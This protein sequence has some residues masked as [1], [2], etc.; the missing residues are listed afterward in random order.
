MKNLPICGDSVKLLDNLNE[1]TVT[2]LGIIKGSI[3]KIVTKTEILALGSFPSGNICKW[4]RHIFG[5]M[6]N[7]QII[8]MDQFFLFLQQSH[9]LWQKLW[10]RLKFWQWSLCCGAPISYVIDLFLVT[11]YCFIFDIFHRVSLRRKEDKEACVNVII[12]TGSF[13]YGANTKDSFSHL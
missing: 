8:W 12:K 10:P 13:N 1:A 4:K 11:N 9:V 6:L 5:D 3:T 2:Y 7:W